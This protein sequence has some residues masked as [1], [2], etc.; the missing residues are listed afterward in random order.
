MYAF[1]L[2][3]LMFVRVPCSLDG[4]LNDLSLLFDPIIHLG[5]LLFELLVRLSYKILEIFS[6]GNDAG[7]CRDNSSLERVVFP[8][9]PGQDLE[10]FLYIKVIVV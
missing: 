8:D 3:P 7:S 2:A 4:L 9:Q 10:E 1:P 5:L 6:R